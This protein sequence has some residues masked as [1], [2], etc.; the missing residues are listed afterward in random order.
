MEAKQTKATPII[1]VFTLLKNKNLKVK[2]IEKKKHAVLT[3]YD[4]TKKLAKAENKI[5]V[6]A[7]CQS[8][9]KGFWI[10][11]HEDDLDKIND[12]RQRDN[13]K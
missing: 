1:K 8:R 3:L 5:P 11:V 4:E 7:L 12:I 10:V 9:R 6:I 13:K 2:V